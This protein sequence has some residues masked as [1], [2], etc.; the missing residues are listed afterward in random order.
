MAGSWTTTEI[1]SFNERATDNRG[2]HS[3]VK[4]EATASSMGGASRIGSTNA[5]Q[6]GVAVMMRDL[7]QIQSEVATITRKIEQEK[8][9]REQLDAALVES[10]EQLKYYRDVTKS[11]RIVKDDD[12]ISKKMISKLEYQVAQ[13][14]N[15]L[16]STHKENKA[17]RVAV[18]EA[19]QEKLF[20]VSIYNELK[21]EIAANKVLLV[22]R[23]DEINVV[24]N[25]KQRK[26]V[27]ISNMKQKMFV[28]VDNFAEELLEAK[29]KV[30]DTQ[31]SILEGIRARLQSTFNPLEPKGRRT[32]TP[33]TSGEVV[34]DT[35]AA[36]RQRR[37]GELLKEV[38][39]NSLEELIVTLQKT[40]EEMFQQYNEI[41]SLTTET[42]KAEV[43]NKH[44]EQRL[45]DELSNLAKLEES[46]DHVR[47][48][49]EEKISAIHENMAHYDASYGANLETLSNVKIPLQGIF[50]MMSLDEDP[51]DQAFIATGITDRNTPEYLGQVEQRIDELIQMMK[52][53]KHERLSREDFVRTGADASS[54]AGGRRASIDQTT[55]NIGGVTRIHNL[56]SLHDADDEDDYPDPES[57]VLP[58]NVGQLKG[59]MAKKMSNGLRVGGG[60]ASPGAATSGGYSP[61]SPV[62]PRSSINRGYGESKSSGADNAGSH[63][64]AG[65]GSVPRRL[66]VG[67]PVS[68]IGTYQPEFLSAS[69]RSA[70]SAGDDRVRSASSERKKRVHIQDDTT[71]PR[72]KDVKG[73][74]EPL[75]FPPSAEDGDSAMATEVRAGEPLSPR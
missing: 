48:E 65:L 12:I 24:N 47:V 46:S 19:R 35:S 33:T 36:E 61:H 20:K 28:D 71:V 34:V 53:S 21:K 32:R 54:A 22:E 55:L 3:P 40:E 63:D 37:L 7:D 15:K 18:G 66:S 4:F 23:R 8:K 60:G 27:D 74:S 67:V 59:I 68:P 11:G 70:G 25:K 73:S 56:P 17:L 10:R 2:E 62:G 49:L 26:E 72:E 1:V 42:E 16:S 57:K 43:D 14:R 45:E 13:A 6:S 29:S 50:Q 38:K 51:T 5:S 58:V 41:Q 44:L 52:A 64:S 39:V 9:R 31:A 30:L 69:P 75:G